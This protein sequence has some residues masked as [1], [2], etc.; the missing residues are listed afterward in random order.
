MAD[1]SCS[2]KLLTLRAERNKIISVG[3]P[4]AMYRTNLSHAAKVHS[5]SF[6]PWGRGWGGARGQ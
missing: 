1:R 5:S 4:D 3:F 2:Y 6:G